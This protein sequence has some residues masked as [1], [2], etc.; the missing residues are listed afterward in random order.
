M[1]LKLSLKLSLIYHYN[2][3]Y[4]VAALPCETRTNFAYTNFTIFRYRCNDRSF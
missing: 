1:R 4:S 3:S 2:S